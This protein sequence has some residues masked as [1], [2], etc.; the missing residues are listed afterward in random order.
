MRPISWPPIDTGTS[1]PGMPLHIFFVFSL[2]FYYF[3]DLFLFHFRIRARVFFNHA[4]YQSTNRTRRKLTPL[5]GQHLNFG[6][7]RKNQV[8]PCNT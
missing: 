6:Q 4:Q 8:I 3:K 5:L 7:A 2:L 1:L